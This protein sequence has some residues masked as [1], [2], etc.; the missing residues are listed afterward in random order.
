MW[1]GYPEIAGRG[2]P[3]MTGMFLELPI[4]SGKERVIVGIV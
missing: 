1:R 3:G 2:I 4:L